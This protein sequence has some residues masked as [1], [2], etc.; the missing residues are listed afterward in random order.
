MSDSQE[1]LITMAVLCRPPPNHLYKGDAFTKWLEVSGIPKVILRVKSGMSPQ[2]YF[3]VTSGFL[4]KILKTVNNENGG[5]RHF[6]KSNILSCREIMKHIYSEVID[7]DGS[8]V[9]Q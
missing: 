3:Y 8:R 2:K 1:C 7:F 4:R 9:L 6:Q 5:K